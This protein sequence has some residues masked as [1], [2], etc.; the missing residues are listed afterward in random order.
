MKVIALWAKMLLAAFFVGLMIHAKKEDFTTGIV[1]A[2]VGFVGWAI[3]ITWFNKSL[4]KDV[5]VERTFSQSA[6]LFCLI[7]GVTMVCIHEHSFIEWVFL[8]AGIAFWTWNSF[9]SNKKIVHLEQVQAEAQ[10]Q[11][12]TQVTATEKTKAPEFHF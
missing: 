6:I 11:I 1:M 3:F 12:H 2:G 10:A 5:Y 7:L 9:D 4:T 8:A